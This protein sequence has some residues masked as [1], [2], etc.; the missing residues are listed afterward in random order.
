MAKLSELVYDI[1][2]ALK[3]YSDDT[4]LDNR[5]IIYLYNFKRAKYLRQDLNNFNKSVDNSIIQRVCLELE[6]VSVNECSVGLDCET[7]LRTKKAL[8]KPLELN[9]KTAIDKVKPTNRL[10][11]P[12]NFIKKEKAYYS[13]E[14]SSFNKSIYAF[15]DVDNHIYITSKLDSHKLLEC[16][17]VDAIF[18]DPLSLQ[19]FKNC[20]GCED[21]DSN[22]CFDIDNTDYPLQP[23]Y[24]DVIRNEII[25][26]LA[27]LKAL[28]EDTTNDSID[29]K[30]S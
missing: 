30:S 5:Y 9:T 26:E 19:E 24:V 14:G 25:N 8:P 29:E 6:E 27:K 21:D 4:E 20:C 28:R 17:T 23:H 10:S 7:V 18:E 11:I 2:E 12:F 15:L 22:T 3:E 1:K 13:L 16:I